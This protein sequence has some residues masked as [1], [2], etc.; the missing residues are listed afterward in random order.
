MVQSL[1]SVGA[2][3]ASVATAVGLRRN[4]MVRCS[5]RV[6]LTS[7]E[8]RNYVTLNL[9]RRQELLTLFEVP[10]Y[11]AYVDST[12]STKA[13]FKHSGTTLL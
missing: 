5:I 12:V 1:E 10:V 3:L 4:S 6:L 8:R 9:V 11:L 2:Y 7:Y 13:T